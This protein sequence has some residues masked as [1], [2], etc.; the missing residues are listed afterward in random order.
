M[1]QA[2]FKVSFF[3]P[4]S[5]Y[6]TIKY[7]RPSTGFSYCKW[8]KAGWGLGTSNRAQRRGRRNLHGRPGDQCWVPRLSKLFPRPE[9]LQIVKF[10]WSVFSI[11][12]YSFQLPGQNWVGPVSLGERGYKIVGMYK[13]LV[14]LFSTFVTIFFPFLGC[15]LQQEWVNFCLSTALESQSF[16]PNI[17][18][19]AP[20]NYFLWYF[21]SRAV[22]VDRSTHFFLLQRKFA[23]KKICKAL[24]CKV[25][26]SFLGSSV[27]LLSMVFHFQ[28][29]TGWQINT[30]FPPA[31]EVCLEENMQGTSM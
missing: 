27:V 2:Q 28:G 7:S 13:A 30:F 23:W 25:R 3:L 31:E 11:V 19:C 9:R 26:D 24:Q 17:I 6:D 4:V 1:Q 12:S 15:N 29:R 22:L 20:V 5:S 10:N 8:R 18:S 14:W 21:I 16:C